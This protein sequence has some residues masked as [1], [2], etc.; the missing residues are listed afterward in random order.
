MGD[1]GQYDVPKAD[2]MINFKVGQPAPSMLPLDKIREAATLKFGETDPMFLQ[3]GVIKG[4]PKFRKTLSEFLTKGYQHEVDPEKL[5]VTNGVTGGLS[6]ICS[7]FLQSGDL[8]FMEEPS[9]F[10]AL[11]IMKDFNIN[12]RQ[13]RMEEDGL[14]IDELERLLE[15]GIVP[16]ML[17]TIPTCHNPTGRTLSAEAQ[18]PRRP[19]C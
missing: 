18:A 9:Y 8:V 19:Q 7:L 11:S 4:Y 15:R 13:I 17:Y 12:V 2:E 6:L 5:F 1:Y 14:D 3:Y 10:L 16:K